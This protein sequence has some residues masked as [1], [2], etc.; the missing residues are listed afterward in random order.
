M[1][2]NFTLA[3]DVLREHA[4]WEDWMERKHPWV[5]ILWRWTIALLLGSALVSSLVF[6]TRYRFDSSVRT[7]VETAMD[8]EHAAMMQAAEDARK[9]AETEEAVLQIREA[10]ALARALF[11]IR[12]FTEK[13][14]YSRS[15]LVTYM[16]CPVKRSEATGRSIEEVLGENGQFIAYSAGNDLD[17]G[18]YD[19]ALQFVADWHDGKL[20]ECDIK[21]RYADL[22][23]YGIWLVDDPGKAV[24]ERWHA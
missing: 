2:I 20:P 24:P 12:N 4:E 1:G 14:H 15:D 10:Q 3:V 5:E 6:F 17:K 23:E 8:E 7:A 13:Y 16:M 18:L 11:G 9:K 21:F 22:S 19:L